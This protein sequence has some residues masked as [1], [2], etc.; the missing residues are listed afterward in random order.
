MEHSWS[1]AG[2]T[3]GNQ[4][5]ITRPR[6]ARKQAKSL[7]L[8]FAVPLK[9]GVDLLVPQ[10]RQ[11]LRTPERS[12]DLD[13]LLCDADASQTTSVRTRTARTTL[14]ALCTAIPIQALR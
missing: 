11:V 1:P 12:Q 5:Q 13:W 7:A 14:W 3:G 4:R 8:G 2:A 6:N 9:E 10:R